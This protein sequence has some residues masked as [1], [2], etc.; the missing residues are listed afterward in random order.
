[1]TVQGAFLFLSKK[2]RNNKIGR[3]VGSACAEETLRN[4]NIARE[5]LDLTHLLF[6][7]HDLVLLSTLMITSVK[8]D[9]IRHHHL[10]KGDTMKGNPRD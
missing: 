8:M 3:F 1:M 2:N 10:I 9:T 7:A 4:E 5:S 6:K